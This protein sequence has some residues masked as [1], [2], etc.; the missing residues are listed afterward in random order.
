[1]ATLSLKVAAMLMTKLLLLWAVLLIGEAAA[2]VVIADRMD[3]ETLI[4][5]K[6]MDPVAAAVE[7]QTLI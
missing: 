2:K 4:T 3:F 1:M 6:H 5:A 7:P